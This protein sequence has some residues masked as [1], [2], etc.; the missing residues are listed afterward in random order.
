MSLE[1]GKT[2][3]GSTTNLVDITVCK[4]RSWKQVYYIWRREK[5]HISVIRRQRKLDEA[6]NE[7]GEPNCEVNSFKKNK[8]E[9]RSVLHYRRRL[10]MALYF[11]RL[12]EDGNYEV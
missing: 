2:M 1:A 3:A 6:K 8:D 9:F 10:Q 12:N 7:D 5:D 4:H 11:I